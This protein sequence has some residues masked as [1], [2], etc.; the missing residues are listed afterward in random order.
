MTSMAINELCEQSGGV[1]RK[2]WSHEVMGC[3]GS[4]CPVLPCSEQDQC[5]VIVTR[6]EPTM[7]ISLPRHRGILEPPHTDSSPRQVFFFVQAFPAREDITEVI[8]HQLIFTCHKLC[9]SSE[10]SHWN[11]VN[12]TE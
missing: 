4:E 7:L 1:V 5:E 11:A 12:S 3:Q 6:T 8:G 10:C 9:Q 2:C